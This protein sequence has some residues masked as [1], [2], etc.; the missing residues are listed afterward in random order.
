[1]LPYVERLLPEAYN[2]R[3]KRSWRAAKKPGS[4]P[5]T[6]RT[7]AVKSEPIVKNGDEET[8]REE[9]EEVE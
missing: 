8:S 6:A 1:M 9:E 7:K 4:L 2:D 5:P 3:G